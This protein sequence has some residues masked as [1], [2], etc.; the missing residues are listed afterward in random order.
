MTYDVPSTTNAG[1]VTNT[2]TVNA[3]E[4]VDSDDDTVVVVE[5][6]DL[7]ITKTFADDDVTAGAAG[8]HTF[9]LVVDNLGDSDADIVTITDNAPAGLTFISDDSANCTTTAGLLACSFL[10]LAANSTTTIVVTYDVPSTT[11]AGTVTNTATVA[12]AEDTDSDDDTVAIV[13]DV[14]LSVTKAFKFDEVTAGGASQTFTAHGHQLRCLRRRQ[15]DPDRLGGS[16]PRRE[17]RHRAPTSSATLRSQ[18]ISCSLEH[19]AA[20]A[21][22]TVIVTFIVDSTTDSDATVD[23]TARGDLGRGRCHHRHRLVAIVEDVVSI[24]HQGIPRAT[25]S[26]PVAR[27]RRSPSR[28]PTTASR[29][30]T[31]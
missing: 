15:R 28:S 30:P 11:D 7:E 3:D 6:V 10:H 1:T 9:T 27:A 24:G 5:D 17:R 29:T 8:T 26:R 12:S 2:A 20:G 16:A 25:R 22:A 23:N 19:L 4:D 14:E 21:S 31:T 18:S 13:E